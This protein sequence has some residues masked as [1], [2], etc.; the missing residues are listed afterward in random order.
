MLTGYLGSTQLWKNF[1]FTLS[2][3]SSNFLSCSLGPYEYLAGRMDIEK[4]EKND[5]KASFSN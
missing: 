1:A 2:L 3:V 4:K 5:I